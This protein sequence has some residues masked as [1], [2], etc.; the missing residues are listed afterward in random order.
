MSIECGLGVRAKDLKDEQLGNVK[1]VG[2]LN[3][4]EPTRNT[5]LM[6]AQ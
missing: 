6:F 4:E 3:L 1:K 2:G 5:M